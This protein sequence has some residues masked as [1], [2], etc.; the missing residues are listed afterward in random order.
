MKLI[1]GFIMV[2]SILN[3]SC[4]SEEKELWEG[5][6]IP[7][8][9]PQPA[10]PVSVSQQGFEL[11]RKLFYDP[12]LSRDNSISCG[13]CHIQGSAFSHHGHD[14]SHGIDDKLGSRNAPAVQNMIWNTSF[15]WDGGVSHIDLISVSPIQNELEMD[16]SFANVIRKLN[17]KEDYRKLF[18][19]VFGT[20]SVSGAYFLTAMSQFMSMLVT[21]DSRYDR[22]VLGDATALDAVELEGKQLFD[23]KCASC[24][25]GVLQSDFS[26]RNNGLKSEPFRDGG[27]YHVSLIESDKGKFKVPSLRNVAIT[28]PYMHDGS[29]R[30]LESVLAHYALGVQKSSTLDPELDKNGVIGIPMSTEE[31]TAIIRFLHTLTDDKF[32]RDPRFSEP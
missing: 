32:I 9:F 13:S 8:H 31:R 26:F 17:L 14:V 7:S 23:Q 2:L 29:L 18:K 27:R 30:T 11:G 15:F 20:D 12:I 4:N 3:F 19:E 24:H 25:V 16:E 6:M 10:F 22:Y 5:L 1:F 21:A 28:A